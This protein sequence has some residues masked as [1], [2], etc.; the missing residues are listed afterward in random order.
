MSGS[1]DPLAS[2]VLEATAGIRDG[3]TE[4][5]KSHIATLIGGE[6]SVRELAQ[7][8]FNGQPEWSGRNGEKWIDEVINRAIKRH[9]EEIIEEFL[10]ARRD[11]L[12]EK[13]KEVLA[14]K[15]VAGLLAEATLKRIEAK[16]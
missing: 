2:M 15:D 7:R 11:E 12:R 6:C 14:G 16:Y 10:A 5:L 8:V 1:S 9:A 4:V 13:I 3:I